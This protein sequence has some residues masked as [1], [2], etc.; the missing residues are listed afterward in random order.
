MN[1]FTKEATRAYLFDDS[2]N[3]VEVRYRIADAAEAEAVIT[4]QLKDTEIFKRFVL[5]VRCKDVDGW[6]GGIDA[7]SVIKT[8]G[9]FGLI[10][11]VAVDIVGSMRV[12]FKRKN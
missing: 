7:E 6:A 10:H 3:P 8:P 5:D 12:D 4:D 1:L 2:E 9:T 11:L